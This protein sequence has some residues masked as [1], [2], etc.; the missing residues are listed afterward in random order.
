MSHKD[1][2][3]QEDSKQEKLSKWEFTERA[4]LLN[5]S[6]SNG[7]YKG[8]HTKISGFN[9]AFRIYFDGDDPIEFQQEMV[10]AG[11][12]VS[13]ARRKGYVIYFPKDYTASG[14][15]LE[16]KGNVMIEKITK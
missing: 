11:K 10:T 3:V 6:E 1:M 5:Q 7:K 4:I 13:A 9:E 16:E 14:M 12:L 15:S 2:K 8:L